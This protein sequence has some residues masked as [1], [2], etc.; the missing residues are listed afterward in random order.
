M[1]CFYAKTSVRVTLAFVKLLTFNCK[2]DIVYMR[3]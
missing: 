1:S 2:A 3:S